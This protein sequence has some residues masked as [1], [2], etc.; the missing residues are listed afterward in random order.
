MTF[1]FLRVAYSIIFLGLQMCSGLVN[2]KVS[3]Q[4][5]YLGTI[6]KCI[7]QAKT[8]TTVSLKWIYLVTVNAG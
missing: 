8:F 2:I 4:W 7:I 5:K 6:N 3:G 1:G